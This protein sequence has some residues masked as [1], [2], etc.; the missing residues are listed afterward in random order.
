MQATAFIPAPANWNGRTG[1]EGQ[2]FDRL[3]AERQAQSQAEAG[4]MVEFLQAVEKH[5]PA[6]TIRTPGFAQTRMPL[7]EVV[8]D[9]LATP[10][11]RGDAYMRSFIAILSA[12]MKSSDPAVRVLSQQLA[13][14]LAI[15]HAHFHATD[16]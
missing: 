13:A 1:G 9:Q 10:H 5:R 12:G 11:G 7:H 4:L 6:E 2:H 8:Y 3:E 15:E 16:L 14:Q